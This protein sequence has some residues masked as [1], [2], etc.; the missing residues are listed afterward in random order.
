MADVKQLIA[1]GNSYNIKDTTARD[2]IS[3]MN[4]SFN[5]VNTGVKWLD[6]KDIY[7]KVINF[8]SL[9][10]AGYKPKDVP[11]G[12]TNIQ[13]FVKVYGIIYVGTT[14][15]PLPYVSGNEENLDMITVQ[16]NPTSV[17]IITGS[18][19]SFVSDTYVILEY[20]KNNS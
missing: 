20:T 17:Y 19:M 9:P 8:G 3:N 6:G 2:F 18:D 13:H 16:A 14:A 12:I 11:H 15:L 5:E 7:R 1:N 10:N 4:Y